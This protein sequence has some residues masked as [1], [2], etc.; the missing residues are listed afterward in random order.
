MKWNSVAIIAIVIIVIIVAGVIAY[1]NLNHSNVNT[2]STTLT[3]KSG[4]DTIRIV[5][6]APSITQDLIALGLGKYIV[7]LDK[8]SYQLLQYLNLTSEVPKNITIFNSII[9]PN[10]TGIVL[11]GPTVVLVEVGMSGKYIPQLQKLGINVL[12][13]NA[14]Y[15]YSFSEVEQ[16]IM[17]IATYFNITSSGEKVVNWMN[18]MISQYSKTGNVSVA[19]IDYINPDYTFWTAGGNV[20]INNIIVA[21]GGINVFST[22]SGYPLLSPEKLLLANP[23]VIIIASMGSATYNIS[24]IANIPGIKNV[25]AYKQGKIYVLGKFASD[26]LEEPGPLAVYG[27]KLVHEIVSG[28]APNVVSDDWVRANLNPKLPIFLSHPLHI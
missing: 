3:T 23:Q 21:G 22:Y 26:L 2:S 11:L 15:A 1:Q 14:D 12:P 19:F 6:L 16:E 25:T 7:G 17:K 5:S 4:Q 18:S 24:F 20:F 28:N 10:I 13:L 27:I 8:W 9:S